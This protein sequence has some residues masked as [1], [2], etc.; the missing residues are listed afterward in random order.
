MK[1][2][3][4]ETSQSLVLLWLL[5]NNEKFKYH[6]LKN[7]ITDLDENVCRT[8]QLD[9]RA[10]FSL[11]GDVKKSRI[12]DLAV[13]DQNGK[14]IFYLETKKIQTSKAFDAAQDEAYSRRGIPYGYLV[15]SPRDIQHK[16]SRSDFFTKIV[17]WETIY[18][19]INQYFEIIKDDYEIEEIEKKYFATML[20]LLI[21]EEIK[22]MEPINLDEIKAI[23]LRNTINQKIEKILKK[24]LLERN[25]QDRYYLDRLIG[26]EVINVTSGNAYFQDKEDRYGLIVQKIIG[27]FVLRLFWGIRFDP[28]GPFAFAFIETYKDKYEDERKRITDSAKKLKEKQNIANLEIYTSIDSWQIVKRR[29]KLSEVLRIN[30]DLQ[31]RSIN[32]TKDQI[33]HLSNWYDETTRIFLQILEGAS[34]NKTDIAVENWNEIE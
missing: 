27:E 4:L 32:N 26:F 22:P 19:Q 8:Y 12:P 10:P 23:G 25:G 3:G 2:M 30:P 34:F 5:N 20:S 17:G 16:I 14:I 29:V 13:Q 7:W 1:L 9:P 6:F 18:T 33:M 31:E 15:R 21:K 24:T 11:D 28:T